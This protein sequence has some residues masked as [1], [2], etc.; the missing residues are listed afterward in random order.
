MLLQTTY[1]NSTGGNRMKRTITAFAA[2]GIA[3]LIFGS[4]VQA[5]VPVEDLKQVVDSFL[6]E[7]GYN[8][9]YKEDQGR[10]DLTFTLDNKLGKTDVYIFLYDD[11]LS[12]TAD[13]PLYVTE[14]QFEKAAIFTTLANNDMYYGQFRIDKTYGLI[15][16]RTCNVIE[17]VLPDAAVVDTLVYEAVYYMDYYGDGLAA[18]CAADAD[19][20]ETY[21]SIAT[22]VEEN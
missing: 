10:Y 17:D 4:T 19:P 2:A 11:M 22:P 3:S 5:A 7:A 14:D 18:I 21:D 15:S 12:V 13:C 20:Y 9:E 8:Y 1:I 16:C 6:D